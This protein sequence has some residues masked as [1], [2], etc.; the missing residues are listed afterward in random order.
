[1]R[2]YVTA[3][4]GIDASFRPDFGS[5]R[6]T[7]PDCVTTQSDPAASFS[8]HGVGSVA[9][10]WTTF[11]D[12]TSTRRSFEK[13]ASVTHTLPAAP[14]TPHGVPG[15]GTFAVMPLPPTAAAASGSVARRENRL[16]L[17]VARLGGYAG[18]PQFLRRRE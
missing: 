1:M 6:S 17:I 8:S 5:K 7:R 3:P 13:V 9:R 16:Q 4:T 2:S 14:A 10:V 11:P 12:A 18:P 15:T